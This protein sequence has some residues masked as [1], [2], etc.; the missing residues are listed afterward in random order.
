MGLSINDLFC[1]TDEDFHLMKVYKYM[2]VWCI[3]T[4]DSI[5]DVELLESLSEILRCVPMVLMWAVI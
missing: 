2:D 4:W 5:E 1:E 3:Y